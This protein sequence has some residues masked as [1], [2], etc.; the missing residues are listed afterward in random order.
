LRIDWNA[1]KKEYETGSQTILE[2]AKKFDCHLRTIQRK[3]SKYEWVRFGRIREG[4]SALTPEDILREHRRVL[5]YVRKKL[6][7]SIER[8]TEKELKPEKLP[9]E[10]IRVMKGEREAWGL[11]EEDLGNNKGECF[12]ATEE[13]EEATVPSGAG[14]AVV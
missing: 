12:E 9:A 5:A 10:L 14:K 1:V 7:D 3:A 2:L 4:D 13:M 6:L 11:A 8:C